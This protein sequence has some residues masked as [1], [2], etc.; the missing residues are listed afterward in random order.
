MPTTVVRIVSVTA[1][2]SGSGHPTPALAA[3]RG[4]A[5][6]EDLAT[7]DT[8]Q[9]TF[10]HQTPGQQ[11]PPPLTPPQPPT[12]SRSHSPLPPPGGYGYGYPPPYPPD[13]VAPTGEPLARFSDRLLARLIDYGVCTVVGLALEIPV[14][15]FMF[16]TLDKAMASPDTLDPAAVIVPMFGLIGAIFMLSMLVSYLYEV[17]LLIHNDGQTIGKRVMKLKV[18]TLTG[19]PLTRGFAAKR[20]LAD[21]VASSFIPIYG[22]VDGLWQLND[23][24]YR[25]CLHDKFSQTI[26]VRCAS[27]RAEA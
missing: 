20:W 21:Q 25:Q 14:I 15:I 26:V 23:K 24:P 22:W 16:V 6:T 5:S 13:P 7:C 18:I 27:G 12:T 2:W 17:E 1:P 11:A 10:P 8:Y 4:T 19:A 3:G 9:V